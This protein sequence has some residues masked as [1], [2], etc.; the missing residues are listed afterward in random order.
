MAAASNRDSDMTNAATPQGH[1]SRLARAAGV[2]RLLAAVAV[3][4]TVAAGCA[5]VTH[6]VQPDDV[7]ATRMSV[8]TVN[9]HGSAL[10]LHIATPVSNSPPASFVLYASG[11]GGWFGAAVDMFRT[12]AARGHPTVGFSSRAFLK[13]ERPAHAALN[14]RQLAAD[15]AAILSEGRRALRLPPGTAAILTGW[16]RGA[17]LATIAASETTLIGQTRGVVAIGLGPDEDLAVTENGDDD[18]EGPVTGA[19]TAKAPFNLYDRLRRAHPWRCAVIQSSGDNYLP[20]D[21]ARL[22][23]GADTPDRRL[24][25]VQARNHRFSG[26]QRQFGAALLDAIAWVDRSL[27]GGQ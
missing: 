18:D 24:Y 16:S 10:E 12:I 26:G 3:G 22:L 21:R 15:Y 5:A 25:T 27:P 17:A 14:A 19:P 4:L 11:D 23:F 1:A 2:V 8:T 9:L 6:R 7:V 20:A 13:L